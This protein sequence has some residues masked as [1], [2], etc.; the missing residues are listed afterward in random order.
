LVLFLKTYTMKMYYQ[1]TKSFISLTPFFTL[2]PIFTESN[3]AELN[4]PNSEEAIF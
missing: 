1:K 2:R 4:F 3:N